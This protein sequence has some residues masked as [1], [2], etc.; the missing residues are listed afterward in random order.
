MISYIPISIIWNRSKGTV[1]E[2]TN[3]YISMMPLW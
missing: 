2:E 3:T 1:K